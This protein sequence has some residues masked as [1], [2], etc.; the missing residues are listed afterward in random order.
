MDRESESRP[1]LTINRMPQFLKQVINDQ[2]MNKPS[3]TVRP[4]DNQ[5]DPVTARIFQGLIRNIEVSSNAD[6]A[7]DMAFDDAVTMGFG[8][9]RAVT[10]YAHDAAFEQDIKIKG[11]EN[12]F[13]VYLDPDDLFDPKFGFVTDMVKRD[14]FKKKYGFDPKPVPSGGAGESLEG[15]YDKDKVRVA[16]YWRVD[17][18]PRTLLLLSDGSTVYKD[19]FNQALAAQLQISVM[20]NRDVECPYVEQYVM[21]GQEFAGDATPWAGRWIPIIPVL[22]EAINIEGKRHLQGLIRHAKDPQRNFN[23]WR[24]V[25]TET[26]ALAPLAPWVGYTGQFDTDSE[27]WAKANRKPFAYLQADAITDEST[28]QILPL[29]QRQPMAGIPAGALQEAASASDDMKSV[30]GLYDASLG[31]RSNETSGVAIRA[32]D[33]QGDVST[34]NFVDGFARDSLT[35]LGRILIDLIPKIYDTARV[36]RIIG[37]DDQ[38]ELVR[39]NQMFMGNDGKPVNFDLSTGKYDVVVKVGPSFSTQRE[40]VRSSMLDFIKQYPPAA[41]LLGPF[42]A[43][44][45]EW[46]EA[47]KVAQM[48][49]S[50]LPP[51]A[52]GQDPQRQQMMQHIDQ[53]TQQIASLQGDKTLEAR[54]VDID[55]YKAETDR[56]QVMAP[57]M[58]PQDIQALVLQTVRDVI[59]SPDVLM[60]QPPAG[61][62][63]MGPGPDLGGPPPQQQVPPQEPPQG[64]FSLP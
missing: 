3:I 57:A 8:Y 52:Q 24:T 41:P 55:G 11:V 54:K 20:R 49:Q 7:Y 63:P 45:M 59:N 2:R 4:V 43:K 40:E 33:R 31:A 46:P 42:I 35:H 53:L 62:A 25:A 32:R 50:L 9:I 28:G 5:G 13:T 29:P 56:L 64:G 1:C 38:P 15:W 60:G 30:M 58:S 51:A 14:V 18:R 39:V 19:E 26:V 16:E 27:K 23:Y 22:G 37:S 48:L 12:A 36:V 44:S 34:F 10:E 21:T 6:R 17:T 47:D 61:P